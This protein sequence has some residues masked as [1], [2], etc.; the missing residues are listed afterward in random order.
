MPQN[1]RVIRFIRRNIRLFSGVVF[2][3]SALLLLVAFTQ[4]KHFL[5]DPDKPEIEPW[6]KIV[7]E[8][9]KGLMAASAV[10]FLYDWILKLETTEEMTQII[11][12][13]LDT[14]KHQ[15][16]GA[17]HNTLIDHLIEFIFA[18]LE[19]A[20]LRE[21]FC[22]MSVHCRYVTG[23]KGDDVRL[24]LSGP[25]DDDTP[26]R[27]LS[28]FVF[29]WELDALPPGPVNEQWLEVTNLRVDREDWGRPEREVAGDTIVVK[30]R[31]PKNVK[32][33]PGRFVVYEFDLRTIE[34][35]THPR[36]MYFINNRMVN[37]T[38]RVDA[39]LLKAKSVRSN[40]AAG[41]RSV[42]QGQYVRAP[43]GMGTCQMFVNDLIEGG[44]ATF[45]VR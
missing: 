30:F 43:E 21:N 35:G 31:K 19:D 41:A 6:L 10:A 25:V 15:S 26:R 40:L 17:D 45:T 12:H 4:E 42:T 7:E 39:R 14:I 33:R 1:Q 20:D 2:A 44:V 11:R 38:F 5:V 27:D 18:P 16:K 29:N 9:L 3:L 24:M 32:A 8:I 34:N 13:E 37:P 28:K 36:I 23:Y 22:R